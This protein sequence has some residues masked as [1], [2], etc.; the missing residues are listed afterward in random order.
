[1][2][3]STTD[4]KSFIIG[5]LLGDACTRLGKNAV[6]YNISCTHNPSQYEYLL[7]KME[8]LKE[9]L[10]K[11]YWL[12]DKITKFTGKGVNDGN[13]GKEYLMHVGT[14]GTDSLVTKVRKEMYQENLKMAPMSVLHQLTPIGLAVWYMDDGSLSYR[15]NPNGSIKSR[16]VTLH[17]QGF[18]YQSQLNIV[19]YFKEKWGIET[20]LHKAR[21][22]YKLW[23]NAP[24]SIKF[25]KIIAQ[26]VNQVPCIQYK[27][28][29]K[30]EKK[31]VDLFN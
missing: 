8:I 2:K 4:K 16:N 3:L 20:K 31:T 7:W 19:Q 30:Y 27:L 28:D 26:Y 14:L 6:N 9:N 29:L 12:N 22:K 23:M 5:M 13:K 10:T 17:I 24:N 25:L 11:N 1:M 18:D 21:D 15:K